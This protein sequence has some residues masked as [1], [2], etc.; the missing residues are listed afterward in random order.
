M[1]LNSKRVFNVDV[2]DLDTQE[3]KKY[4]HIHIAEGFRNID[5]NILR[6]IFIKYDEDFKK[7]AKEG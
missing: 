1:L 7:M 2:K 5:A 6:S 3:D 4:S